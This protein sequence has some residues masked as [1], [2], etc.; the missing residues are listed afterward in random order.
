MNIETASK[1]FES[2]ASPIRLEIFRRLV[3]A[4]PSGLVAG[5]LAAALQLP[6]ANLS[7]HLKALTQALL[8]SVTAEGRFQ[9]YRANLPL[10][11]ELLGYL[12]D[13]C[14]GGKP[15]LCL[16]WCNDTSLC[17]QPEP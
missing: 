10:M 14:C 12:T 5:E 16:P 17:D 15:Q 3:K 4:G 9:R 6:P 7:F 8:V 13:E 2:L 11:A 1:L